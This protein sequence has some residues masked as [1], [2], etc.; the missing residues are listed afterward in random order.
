MFCQSEMVISRDLK[1]AGRDVKIVSQGKLKVDCEFEGD[2]AGTEVVISE[3][4]RVK[5][6]VVGERV[7]VLGKIIGA[8]HGNDILLMSS[9]HVEGDIHHT[10]LAIETGAEFDGRS[11]LNDASGVSPR[12]LALETAD[13]PGTPPPL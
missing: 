7:I 4:G 8:I 2:V 11:R 9:A 3:R 12:L 6:K 13:A 5:G 10:S 1:F